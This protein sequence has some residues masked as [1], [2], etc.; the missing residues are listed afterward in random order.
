M[1]KLNSKEL[2][3][4]TTQDIF[5][6]MDN[7]NFK[8]IFLRFWHSNNCESNDF[9]INEAIQIYINTED[10]NLKVRILELLKDVK[11]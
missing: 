10:D 6:Y 3:K 9:I 4:L 11:F 5:P 2:D 7:E 1:V 8:K